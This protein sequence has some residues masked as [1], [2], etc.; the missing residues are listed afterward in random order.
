MSR[1]MAPVILGL[2]AFPLAA[3]GIGTQRIDGDAAVLA[4]LALAEGHGT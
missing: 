4:G 1:R 2:T 3:I